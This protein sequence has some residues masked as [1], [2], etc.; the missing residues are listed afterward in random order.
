[1]MGSA[2]VVMAGD[3]A[4][5]AL[6]EV[7][8]ISSGNALSSLSRLLGGDRLML[9]VPE[10]VT[11]DALSSMTGLEAKGLIVSMDVAG[12]VSC[13][14]LVFF[15]DPSTLALAAELMSRDPAT[16]T[17]GEEEH[18]A[19]VEVVNIISCSFLGALASMLRGVLIP[20]PP[21][22]W[23]GVLAECLRHELSGGSASLTNRFEATSG[24]FSGRVVLIAGE[25]AAARIV[26]ALGV[27]PVGG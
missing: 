22:A 12:S 10:L 16:M 1:M 4:R 26:E 23:H 19:I 20:S 24:A 18:S 5:D 15:D 17:F 7:T 8:N 3:L 9:F 14:L 27:R 11:V 2:P 21:V 13:R 6:L 25:A